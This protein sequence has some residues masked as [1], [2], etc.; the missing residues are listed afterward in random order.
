MELT[1]S[2]KKIAL[3]AI[4][5]SGIALAISQSAIAQNQPAAKAPAKGPGYRQLDPAMVEEP[6]NSG[7]AVARRKAAYYA[8]IA[9]RSSYK[10]RLSMPTSTEAPSQARVDNGGERSARTA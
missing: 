3:A 10:D 7:G 8:Q 9:A 5:T 1:T 6:A 4:L 2:T